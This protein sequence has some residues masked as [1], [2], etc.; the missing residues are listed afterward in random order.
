MLVVRGVELAL[1]GAGEAGRRA[2]FDHCADQAKIGRG[3]PCHDPAGGIARVG[4]V[5]VEPNAAD[6]L[7]QIALGQTSVRAGCAAGATVETLVDTAEESVAIQA[8]R[9]WMQV[10]DLVESRVVPP[11]VEASLVG[12]AWLPRGS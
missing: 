7:R 1:L 9:M 11:S 10:D 8:A 4:A 3:L 2:G 12:A 6:Q 5:E